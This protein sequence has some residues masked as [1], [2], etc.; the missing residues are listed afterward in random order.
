MLES[1]LG[2]SP[3]MFLAFLISMV[4]N[5]YLAFTNGIKDNKKKKDWF[6]IYIYT[7]WTFVMS[8]I[9]IFYWNYGTF[10]ELDIQN[11]IK[12]CLIIL[13]GIIILFAHTKHK[14]RGLR[15]PYTKG[16]LSG[17][18]KSFPQVMLIPIA[19]NKGVDGWNEGTIWVGHITITIRI[20]L[21]L[22][23]KR[24]KKYTDED[25]AIIYAELANSI[26][27]IAF[28]LVFITLK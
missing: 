1:T 10:S 24:G 7:T 18:L 2:L 27:W 20:T 15:H 8:M 23:G 3:T 16:Y 6:I 22:L 17:I 4:I 28:H 13:S 25:K 14:K 5:L 12:M 11:E 19:Y 9:L 26:S 21:L